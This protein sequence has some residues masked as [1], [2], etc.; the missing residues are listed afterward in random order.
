VAPAPVIAFGSN[1]RL[2][3]ILVFA[4]ATLG[5]LGVDAAARGDAPAAA[6]SIAWLRGWFVVLAAAG[7]A[8]SAGLAAAAGLADGLLA[9]AGLAAAEGL[10]TTAGLAA[11]AVVLLL[12]RHGNVPVLAWR[13]WLYL[14]TL[15]V[16]VLSTIFLVVIWYQGTPFFGVVAPPEVELG[17]TFMPEEPVLPPVPLFPEDPGAV[18]KLGYEKLPVGK[19][20]LDQYLTAPVQ[21]TPFQRVLVD[22]AQAVRAHRELAASVG[23]T[24]GASNLRGRPDVRGTLIIEQWAPNLKKIDLQLRWKQVG[25]KQQTIGTITCPAETGCYGKIIYLHADSRYE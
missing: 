3:P 12:V 5:A 1:L 16:A 7:L 13:F 22:M 6:R 10:A 18:R 14:Y 9:A 19:Y 15:A 2:M 17:Q 20:D 21:A 8:A 24:T 4:L 11:V 23:N 25:A